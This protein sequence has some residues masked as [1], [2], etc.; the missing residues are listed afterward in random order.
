MKNKIFKVIWIL[1]LL[2][3]IAV[4]VLV[5]IVFKNSY[6][7]ANVT[8]FIALAVIEV[9]NIILGILLFLKKDN[10][11]IYVFYIIFVIISLLIP[12]YHN[13]NYMAPSGQGRE[14]MGVAY[15]ERFLNIYGINI[16]RLIDFI[17]KF[18]R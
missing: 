12:I 17:R 3:Q 5:T 15:N 13:G 16:V 11:A 4:F 18:I 8:N 6:D 7:V 10:K 14:L 1:S 9:I 2:V